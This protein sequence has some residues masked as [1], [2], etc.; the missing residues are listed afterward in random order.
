MSHL[1][2]FRAKLRPIP[3]PPVSQAT[4]LL[5][6]RKPR[7]EVTGLGGLWR[8]VWWPFKSSGTTDALSGVGP[9]SSAN[10]SWE[11]LLLSC[12]VIREKFQ[13]AFCSV[14]SVTEVFD[15]E[16]SQ[17]DLLELVREFRAWRRG[18]RRL[19]GAIFSLVKGVTFRHQGLFSSSAPRWAW[20]GGRGAWRGEAGV[21]RSRSWRKEEG[22]YRGRFPEPAELRPLRHVGAPAG[23]GA[24]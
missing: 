4:E 12:F 2:A 6:F 24:R 7:L 8:A 13:N 17:P 9:Q 18:P 23:H 10:S 15:D 5:L 21:G 3:K 11:E 22:P 16:F 14:Q 19:G 20:P 1:I